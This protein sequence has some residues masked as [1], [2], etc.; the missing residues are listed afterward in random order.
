MAHS[1]IP[2]EATL[3]T[4]RQIQ[5]MLSQEEIP[6]RYHDIFYTGRQILLWL[7][8]E[9]SLYHNF[10]KHIPRLM[11]VTQASVH[12]IATRT[13]DNPTSGTI[14][15]MDFLD[16]SKPPWWQN[17]PQELTELT[18]YIPTNSGATPIPGREKQA[19]GE[20]GFPPHVQ[21]RDR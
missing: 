12:C 15:I 14:A 16:E 1:A 9:K 18:P 13:V 19:A 3:E 21:Q 2:G 6:L 11:H 17:P 7:P 5:D 10:I 20:T 4:T 8:K